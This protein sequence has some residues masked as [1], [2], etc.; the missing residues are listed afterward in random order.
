[1]LPLTEGEDGRHG[2]RGRGRWSCRTRG[3]GRGPG[4]WPACARPRPPLGPGSRCCVTPSPV[5]GRVGL[6]ADGAGDAAGRRLRG[7]RRGGAAWRVFPHPAARDRRRGHHVSEADGPRP[8]GA[9]PA[10]QGDARKRRERERLEHLEQ[11]REKRGAGGRDPLT[12]GV[13]PS[14]LTRRQGTGSGS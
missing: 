5:A 10:A 12:D 4:G 14:R 11:R 9:S 2:W 13:S 3:T 7:R 6:A 1:M 8:R